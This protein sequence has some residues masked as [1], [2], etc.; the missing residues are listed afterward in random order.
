MPLTAPTA[1][2][3]SVRGEWADEAGR[4]SEGDGFVA[5]MRARVGVRYVPARDPSRTHARARQASTTACGRL[6]SRPDE[7]QTAGPAEGWQSPA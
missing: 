4:A 7:R 2:L 5:H 3:G 6:Y 1:A